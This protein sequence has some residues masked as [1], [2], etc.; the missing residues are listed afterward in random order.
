MEHV[1][2]GNSFKETAEL[3]STHR[4]TV[5]RLTRITGEH[6]ARVHDHLAQ[7]LHVTSLEADEAVPLIGLQDQPY[8][9][10]T[11]LDPKSKFV[12]QNALGTRTTDLAVQ[13]LFGA[14]AR[15]HDHTH[16]D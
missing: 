16:S 11:V 15:L 14:R 5:S 1:T 6:A 10:A 7:N 3:T 2:R 9:E 4:T 12:V 13:L 8:W